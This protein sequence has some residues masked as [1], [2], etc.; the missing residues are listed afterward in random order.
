M[1]NHPR[2]SPT[3]P[4]LFLWAYDENICSVATE[5]NSW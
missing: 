3:G 1:M 2:F 5:K 4:C